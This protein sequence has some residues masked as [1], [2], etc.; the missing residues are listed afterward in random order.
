MEWM[1]ASN[2]LMK[3]LEEQWRTK[4]ELSNDLLCCLNALHG[5]SLMPAL[6]LIDQQK[7]GIGDRNIFFVSQELFI[8]HLKITIIVYV[9]KLYIKLA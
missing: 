9:T 8:V 1:T 7:V 6:Q 5:N 2:S 3:E 4:G